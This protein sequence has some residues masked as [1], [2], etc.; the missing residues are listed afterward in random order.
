MFSVSKDMQQISDLLWVDFKCFQLRRCSFGGSATLKNKK[1]WGRNTLMF[2]FVYIASDQ[3]Y[4]SCF[5]N[6][7]FCI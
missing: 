2:A 5:K 6:L 4:W 3:V 7:Y 1:Y